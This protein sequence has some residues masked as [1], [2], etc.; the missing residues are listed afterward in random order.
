MPVV[1]SWVHCAPHLGR[2]VPAQQQALAALMPRVLPPG[3]VLFRPGDRAM[4]FAIVLEGRVEV[5]LNSPTGRGIL[6]YAVEPGESC[7]QTTLGLL[8]GEEYAGEAVAANEVRAVMIPRGLFLDLMNEAPDFRAYVFRA[9]G[10]RMG[11]ITRMLERV[12]F[13]TVEARLA[14]ALLDLAEGAEVRVTQADLAQRIGSA[15]EV[16][17]R[18]LDALARRGLVITERGLIRLN[19][20]EGLRFLGEDGAG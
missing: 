5:F 7:V 1:M 20:I 12:A 15:R 10:Q 8:A 9:F 13:Q 6:L 17:S 3:A 16:V 11:A 14:R 18:R 4:G 19:D 2:L